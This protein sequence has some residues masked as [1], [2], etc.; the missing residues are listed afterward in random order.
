MLQNK[1]EGDSQRI[2]VGDVNNLNFGNS[3]TGSSMMTTE[4]QREH[5]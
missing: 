5:I 3:K 4:S 1:V 2:T